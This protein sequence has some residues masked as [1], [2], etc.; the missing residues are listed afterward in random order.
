MLPARGVQDDA[1]NPSLGAL[2]PVLAHLEPK[3][4]VFEKRLRD[5]TWDAELL[6]VNDDH[7]FFSSTDRAS[8]SSM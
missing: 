4:R 8:S 2:G 3:A 6:P 7:G 1:A 5:Q